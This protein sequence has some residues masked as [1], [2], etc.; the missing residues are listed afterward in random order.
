M[1]FKISLKVKRYKTSMNIQNVIK[2]RKI[3]CSYLLYAIQEYSEVPT[4]GQ[5]L[6]NDIGNILGHK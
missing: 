6:K 4:V 1:E 5:S 2:K 3:K